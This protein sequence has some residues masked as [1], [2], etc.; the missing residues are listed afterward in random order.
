MWS[1]TPTI[2]AFFYIT[3]S[4]SALIKTDWDRSPTQ[5]CATW[6]QDQLCFAKTFIKTSH[7]SKASNV[8]ALPLQRLK[9]QSWLG[10]R[11]QHKPS[12]FLFSYP[13]L[14]QMPFSSFLVN[15]NKASSTSM[16]V[17]RCPLWCECECWWGL[18]CSPQQLPPGPAQTAP[19]AQR[20]V[21]NSSLRLWFFRSK[22]SSN[23]T[24]FSYVF[25]LISF[26]CRFA[27]ILGWITRPL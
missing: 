11:C 23:L 3:H 15:K 22:S 14:N 16:G 26:L 6:A 8:W 13:C 10:E 4:G 9:L 12:I 20:D 17:N 1:L 27:R 24:L 7:E 21:M 2:N 5:L 19:S 18:L 25:V